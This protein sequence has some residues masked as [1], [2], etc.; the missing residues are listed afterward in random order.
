MITSDASTGIRSTV[1]C[2]MLQRTKVLSIWMN[3]K[4]ENLHNL[5]STGQEFQDRPAQQVAGPKSNP[6]FGHV[7]NQ[8]VV[9]SNHLYRPIL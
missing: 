4:N 1:L 9:R 7:T 6:I 8:L 2:T 3:E 5:K